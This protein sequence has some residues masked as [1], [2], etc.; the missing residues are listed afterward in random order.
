MGNVRKLSHVHNLCHDSFL[1]SYYNVVQYAK[2]YKSKPLYLMF[3]FKS[4][5][6][7]IR[8]ETH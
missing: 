8:Q 2:L 7:Y 4:C 6:K 3:T 5:L 1:E